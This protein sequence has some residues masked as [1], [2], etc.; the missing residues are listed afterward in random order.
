MAAR[1]KKRLKRIILPP[2]EWSGRI[3]VRLEPS[4]SR[5]FRYL[6]EAYDNLAY[7]SVVD[8]KGCIFKVVFSPHQEAELRRVLKEMGESLPFEVIEPPLGSIK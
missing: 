6:L 8:R 1:S 2:P 5:L 7:S 4:E 3:Y